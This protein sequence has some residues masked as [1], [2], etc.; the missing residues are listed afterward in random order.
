MIEEEREDSVY[1]CGWHFISVPY[2]A[3]SHSQY[4]IYIENANVVIEIAHRKFKD[5]IVFKLS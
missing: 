3:T 5:S 4:S 1:V 2:W